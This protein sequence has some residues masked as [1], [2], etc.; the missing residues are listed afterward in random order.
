MNYGKAIKIIRSAKGINQKQLA[1]LTNL[2]P[3]Y[4]SLIESNQRKPTLKTLERISKELSVPVPLLTLLASN[5]K[6]LKDFNGKFIEK[7]GAELLNILVTSQDST[8]NAKSR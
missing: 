8:E 2:D 3:S 4:I 6:Q 1:G 7:I 5:G